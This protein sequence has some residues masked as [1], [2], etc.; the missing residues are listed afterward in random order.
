MNE[1]EKVRQSVIQFE[2]KHDPIMFLKMAL[3]SVNRLLVEKGIVTTEELQE[4]FERQINEFEQQHEAQLLEMI[5]NGRVDID[6]LE[7]AAKEGE[8]GFSEF[9]GGKQ[10]GK[11]E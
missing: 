5:N 1:Q 10:S 9:L 3:S 11:S 8:S 6:A 2:K 7:E 4:S